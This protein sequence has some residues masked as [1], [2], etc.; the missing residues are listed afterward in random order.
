MKRK[1]QDILTGKVDMSALR[2]L[3]LFFRFW[4]GLGDWGGLP[5]LKMEGVFRNLSEDRKI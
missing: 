1:F 4:G 5:I 3:S 2:K